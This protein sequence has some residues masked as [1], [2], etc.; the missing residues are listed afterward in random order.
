MS[1]KCNT[2][3]VLLTVA[4]ALL[5]AIIVSFF[6]NIEIKVREDRVNMPRNLGE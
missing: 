6:V 4:L 5:L 3:A 1:K 2:G